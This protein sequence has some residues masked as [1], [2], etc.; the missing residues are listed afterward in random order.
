M[1]LVF[2]V[3]GIVVFPGDGAQAPKHT[4]DTHQMYEYNRWCAFSWY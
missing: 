1:Y 4:E 3:T 2:Q